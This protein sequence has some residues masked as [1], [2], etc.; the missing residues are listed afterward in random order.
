VTQ[1]K[2]ETETGHDFPC[3]LT[4]STI[5]VSPSPALLNETGR[6]DEKYQTFC[7]EQVLHTVLEK[8][9]AA[10]HI[11]AGLTSVLLQCNTC[12]AFSLR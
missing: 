12:Q 4:K 7:R 3:T 11:R 8:M 6:V 2:G 9:G 1:Q 10:E 5:K